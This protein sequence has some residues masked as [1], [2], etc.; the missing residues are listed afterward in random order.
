MLAAPLQSLSAK[1]L[2][3]RRH[4]PNRIS[5]S[6]QSPQLRS[7]VF[8]ANYGLGDRRHHPQPELKQ[9][10]Q[11]GSPPFLTLGIQSRLTTSSTLRQ[12]LRRKTVELI[13]RFERNRP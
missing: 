1:Q 6:C 13:F 8:Y 7:S 4:H 9:D 11:S 12:P 2:L 5:P 10:N 3:Q